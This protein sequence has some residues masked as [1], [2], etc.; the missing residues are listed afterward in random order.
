MV[1][2]RDCTDTLNAHAHALGGNFADSFVASMI[3]LGECQDV[4]T[5]VRVASTSSKTPIHGKYVDLSPKLIV[6]EG[7]IGVGKSTL[8]QKIADDLDFKLF[9]EPSTEN[10][11]LGMAVTTAYV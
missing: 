1:W 5:K 7:N 9:L 2:E 10:P 8:A 3:G 11:Y 4:A 6:V